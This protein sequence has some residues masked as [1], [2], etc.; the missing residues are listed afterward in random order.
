MGM[1]DVKNKSRAFLE[2]LPKEDQVEMAAA[3]VRGALAAADLAKEV[4]KQWNGPTQKEAEDLLEGA[5]QILM[6][7]LLVR[8]TTSE[9]ITAII[10]LTEYF[11]TRGNFDLMVKHLEDKV[12]AMLAEVPGLRHVVALMRK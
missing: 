12:Q 2:G 7:P 8:K 10:L 4:R 5:W 11:R 3:A 6:E 1:D 9:E